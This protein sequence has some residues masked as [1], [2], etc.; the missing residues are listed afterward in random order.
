MINIFSNAYA[1]QIYMNNRGKEATLPNKRR[2]SDE[3]M[4]DV[5][6]KLERVIIAGEKLFGPNDPYD[7]HFI[8]WPGHYAFRTRRT[9][10]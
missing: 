6:S 9:A 1:G 7:G 8:S 2:F 5:F 4:R 3:I 10:A